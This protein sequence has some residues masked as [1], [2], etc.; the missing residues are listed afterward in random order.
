M[1]QRSRVLRVSVAA[2]LGLVSA[3]AV[4]APA[5]TS[6]L[7][8]Y[9]TLG[10]PTTLSIAGTGLCATATGTC[11]TAPTVSVGGTALTVTASTSSSVTAT[12]VAA[13]PDGDYTL[14]LAAGTS[15]STTYALTIE[16]LDKGATGPTG[17][18]GPSGVPGP[19]GST[20]S[21]GAKGSTGATGATGPSGG[22]AGPTGPTGPGT[23]SFYC[24]SSGGSHISNLPNVAILSSQGATS[25]AVTG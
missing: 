16:S 6:I 17:P 19:T 8:S 11:A 9:S 14:S 10:T 2:A 5:I 25:L 22:P 15:G 13:P 23:S 3:A 7:T 18:T 1:S 20:G 12:F 4:S 24:Q 21:A